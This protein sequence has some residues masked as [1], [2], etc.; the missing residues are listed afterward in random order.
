MRS[1][2]NSTKGARSMHSLKLVAATTHLVTPRGQKKVP[3]L[4]I[5]SS[6]RAYESKK[7][8]FMVQV[9]Q[10][11]LPALPKNFDECVETPARKARRKKRTQISQKEN[12]CPG[13]EKASTEMECVGD[14]VPSS[15]KGVIIE[16]MQRK[17]KLASVTN[18]TTDS[19]PRKPSEEKSEKTETSTSLV[20]GLKKTDKKKKKRAS[21]ISSGAGSAGRVGVKNGKTGE[22][23]TAQLKKIEK[24]KKSTGPTTI[25][26]NVSPAFANEQAIKGDLMKEPEQKSKK[27]GGPTRNTKP[28]ESFGGD[29]CD[30]HSISDLSEYI[31]PSLRREK[32]LIYSKA[33]TAE[34]RT[35]DASLVPKTVA[36]IDLCIHCAVPPDLDPGY[37]PVQSTARVHGD[38]IG[39]KSGGRA[40]S[41]NGD[42]KRKVSREKLEHSN[43]H[44]DAHKPRS[45]PTEVAKKKKLAKKKKT[46]SASEHKHYLATQVEEKGVSSEETKLNSTSPEIPAPVLSSELKPRKKKIKKVSKKSD[47]TT[48]HT[49]DGST[50]H[51]NN[52]K[53]GGSKA[54]PPEVVSLNTTTRLSTASNKKISKVA[55][56]VMEV[57]DSPSVVTHIKKRASRTTSVNRYLTPPSSPPSYRRS[58]EFTSHKIEA[59]VFPSSP[60]PSRRR[61]AVANYAKE[62]VAR[63][64]QKKRLEEDGSATT[65]PSTSVGSPVK[66]KTSD[67]ACGKDSYVDPASPLTYN[68]GLG[69]SRELFLRGVGR[70]PLIPEEAVGS[71]HERGTSQWHMSSSEVHQSKSNHSKTS[72]SHRSKT[73]SM[74]SML[75]WNPVTSVTQ[76]LKRRPS[77]LVIATDAT[78]AEVPMTV[79]YVRPETALADVDGSQRV[80]NMTFYDTYTDD[81]FKD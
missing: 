11:S 76:M 25:D 47:G 46:Q 78:D 60:K 20:E 1:S 73:R 66:N 24:R 16:K 26:E 34:T 31:S 7:D 71:N 38:G 75:S 22:Q 44:M 74:R 28:M 30:V 57:Q 53:Q 39:G 48:S 67:R 69:S 63:S 55:P 32:E 5:S 12:R 21:Q 65:F 17:K 37:V 19:P 58:A 51:S 13:Q 64:R 80:M 77:E 62:R 29:E 23:A 50:L 8:C 56:L 43:Q 72:F 27:K 2:K 9:R 15:D 36:Q 3:T 14:R 35:E 79:W 54:T 42:D 45:S 10:G 18:I 70:S 49:R 81:S 33:R 68:S 4:L 6:F 41:I 61:I 52:V 59:P 40:D